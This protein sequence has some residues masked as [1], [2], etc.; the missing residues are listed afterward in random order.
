MWYH[1][2]PALVLTLALLGGSAAGGE[3]PAEDPAVPPETRAAE[4]PAAAER[5]PADAELHR[6]AV[7]LRR[8]AAYWRDSG[9]EEK[10]RFFEERAAA[11]ESGEMDAP[12]QRPARRPDAERG[13]LPDE[14]QERMRARRTDREPRRRP[15]TQQADAAEK[16]FE[17][18][19]V[20]LE[21]ALAAGDDKLA[22]TIRERIGLLRAVISHEAQIKEQAAR[23][24]ELERTVAAFKEL[25]K[26]LASDAGKEE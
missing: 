11:I 10:A 4:E 13:A 12:G 19:Q 9:D 20:E 5:K 24:E 16:R 23:I 18:L 17:E 1:G 22:K 21:N 7:F 26:R 3:A 25:F 14:T 8:A 15:E 6:R 2:L